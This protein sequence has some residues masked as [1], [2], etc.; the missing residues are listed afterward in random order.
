MSV[1]TYLDTSE[2]LGDES[3]R[4]FSN[5]YRHFHWHIA[6]FEQ[7]GNRLWGELEISYDGPARPDGIPHLGSIEYTAIASMLA[8]YVLVYLVKLDAEQVSLSQLRRIGVKLR[9]TIDV[10]GVATLPFR[11]TLGPADCTRRAFN[12]ILSPIAVA[13]AGTEVSLICDHPASRWG[14]FDPRVVWPV[15]R[16]AMHNHGYKQRTNVVQHICCDDSGQ[17]CTAQVTRHNDYSCNPRG[18]FSARDTII[19]TDV[20]AVTGQL[21]QILL[22]TLEGMTREAC[23]NIWLRGMDIRYGRPVWEAVYPARVHFLDTKTLTKRT[24][25]WRM[26]RLESD[27]GGIYGK[28]DITHRLPAKKLILCK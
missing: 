3:V 16:L 23:G 2:F 12:G 25:Q 14:R 27:V 13:L 6:V 9:K 20:L 22:Y 18:L 28:F 1:K 17:T 15:N 7:D 21:M 4:Y 19:P 11:C 5:G 10:P 8:E 24:E 26:V